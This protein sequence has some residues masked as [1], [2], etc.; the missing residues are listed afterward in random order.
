MPSWIGDWSDPPVI[1]TLLVI[2]SGALLWVIKREGEAV[3]HEMQPNS[4]KSMR[5]A[6]NRIEEKLDQHIQ[7]HLDRKE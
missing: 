5:D 6:V 3:Q 7:W 4:G 1:L 2:F